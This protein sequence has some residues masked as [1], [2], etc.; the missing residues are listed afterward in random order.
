MPSKQRIAFVANTS[1]SIYKFRLQLLKAFV[2]KGFDV[3]VLAPR[4]KYSSFFEH[5]EGIF[6]IELKRFKSKSISVQ[7]DL[8]LYRELLSHYKS[9]RPG[10]IFHYTIKANIYGSL[11][12]AR[13]SC[14]AVAVITGLGYMFTAKSIFK[15][16]ASLLYRYALKKTEEVWFLNHDD[17]QIFIK[18][19][20]V[21]EKKTF[22]LPGEGVDTTAFHAAPYEYKTAPISFLLIA[23][24]IEHKG[25]YEFAAAANLLH[26]KKLNVQFSILGFFDEKSAVAIPRERLNQWENDKT[27]NYL[28][29]TDNV[30]PFIAAADC[31]VL[32]SYRE[33][34]PLSLLEGASMCKALIATDVAG[35]R[36][37]IRD[38]VNG[39][40]CRE[41]DPADLAAK[42][43]HYYALPAAGKKAMGMA[44]RELVLNHFTQ[45]IVTSIYLAKLNLLKR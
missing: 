30:I 36:E 25:V 5:S 39:L 7:D 27:I 16:I 45:D 35:C 33:G 26:A 2:Q 28:G 37:V 34:L 44:G 1:W 10:L 41:K 40:L 20:L 32:P 3:Y 11:A 6:F 12:A 31:I 38:G 21:P 15:F 23:R 8:S 9:I 43:E 17:Q 29:A 42:M 18:A 4:D 22:I 14:P 13:A 24:L 19:G